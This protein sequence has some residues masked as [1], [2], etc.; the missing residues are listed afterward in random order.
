[1]VLIGLSIILPLKYYKYLISKLAFE[2]QFSGGVL[3]QH[4]QGCGFNHYHCQNIPC[5]HAI[6]CTDYFL[7]IQTLACKILYNQLAKNNIKNLL[8]KKDFR[9]SA[10][11]STFSNKKIKS[12]ISLFMLV[13][14]A[15]SFPTFKKSSDPLR[16]NVVLFFSQK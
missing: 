8:W 7:L 5:S 2:M 15:T 4:M 9:S 16:Y 11:K 10:Q 14:Q 3:A 1:M 13:L 6:I 12:V